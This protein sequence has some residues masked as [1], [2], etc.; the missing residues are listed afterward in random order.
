MSGNALG[1]PE[2]VRL[3]RDHF[4]SDFVMLDDADE[5]AAY[6]VL[7]EFRYQDSVYA[8][9]QSEELKKEHEVAIFKVTFSPKGEPELETIEDDDEWETVSELYDEMSFPL[10]DRP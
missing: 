5:S 8:V 7:A 1:N 9:L 4:G 3:L 10:Q 6:R 2:P